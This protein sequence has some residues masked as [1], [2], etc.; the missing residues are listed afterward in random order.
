MET[1]VRVQED[2]HGGEWSSHWY[3]QGWTC[4]PQGAGNFF[5]PE[6]YG[7][8]VSA[9]QAERAPPGRVRVDFEGATKIGQLFFWGGDRG[10]KVYPRENH[11]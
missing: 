6:L 7:K 9:P 11:G 4:T 8:V 5:G 10:R 1:D 3:S 2:V